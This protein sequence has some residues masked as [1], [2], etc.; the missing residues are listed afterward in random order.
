M[1]PSVWVTF[2]LPFHSCL[3]LPRQPFIEC[4][5]ACPIILCCK[6]GSERH[7]WNKRSEC[8]AQQRT[9]RQDIYGRN[10]EEVYT[11][12]IL[13]L[14]RGPL[15]SIAWY[16]KTRF[17]SIRIVNFI[18][19]LGR[20]GNSRPGKLIEVVRVGRQPTSQI[21]SVIIFF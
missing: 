11:R 7:T 3:W 8:P 4:F 12:A 19:E 10:P 6:M 1:N 16:V 5:G 20:W 13:K 21:S 18:R 14:I 9:E 15:R 17:I 2:A